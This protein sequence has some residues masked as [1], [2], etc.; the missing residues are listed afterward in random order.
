MTVDDETTWLMVLAQGVLQC[1]LS[2][3]EAGTVDEFEIGID[4]DS[5]LTERYRTAGDRDAALHGVILLT[6]VHRTHVVVIHEDGSDEYEI[7]TVDENAP[8]RC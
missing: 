7:L 4:R 1:E 2:E 3:L 8:A 6:R 5:V